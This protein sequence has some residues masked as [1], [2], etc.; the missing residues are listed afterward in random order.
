MGWFYAFVVSFFQFDLFL[1]M[2]F[3]YETDIIN[4]KH[5]AYT[6]PRTQKKNF[7]NQQ[8]KQITVNEKNADTKI[9]VTN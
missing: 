9:Y 7:K 1:V 8:N 2:S 3:G 4:Y 5:T 6:T